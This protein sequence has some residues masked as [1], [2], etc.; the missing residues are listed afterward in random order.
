MTNITS[1]I[2]DPAPGTT[3]DGSIIRTDQYNKILDL[4]NGISAE[5][6]NLVQNIVTKTT[7]YSMVITDFH[8]LAN[9]VSAG[10]T[11]TLPDAT[12]AGIKNK[13]LTIKKIDSTANVI[14]VQGL[15]AQTIDGAN[16]HNLTQQN[17]TVF[18]QSDGTNWRIIAKFL[19]IRAIQLPLAPVLATALLI[20]L[21]SAP[22]GS[23]SA[24]IG[25]RDVSASTIGFITTAQSGEYVTDRIGIATLTNPSS[26]TITNATTLKI[27]GAPVASTNVTITNAYSLW[28]AGG[29]SK[30]DG[31]VALG[32]NTVTG[33][34][35][36]SGVP[37]VSNSASQAF[38]V[39]SSA[40]GGGIIVGG[41]AF[42]SVVLNSTQTGTTQNSGIDS[43]FVDST[44]TSVRLTSF[45]TFVETT[46]HGAHEGYVSIYTTHAGSLTEYFRVSGKNQNVQILNGNLSLSSNS[47]TTTLYSILDTFPTDVAEAIVFTPTS[48]NN[49][50]VIAVAPHGSNVAS[51]LVSYQ[52]GYGASNTQFALFGT[53]AFAQPE[54]TIASLTFGTASAHPINIYMQSANAGTTTKV[55]AFEADKSVSLYNIMTVRTANYIQWNDSGNANAFSIIHSPSLTWAFQFNGSTILSF[56]NTGITTMVNTLKPI[57]SSGT[58][59][60]SLDS[61]GG[62][63][64]VLTSGSTSTPFSNADNFAGAFIIYNTTSGTL[65]IVKVSASAVTMFTG[66]DSEF[67]NT[68]SPSSSQTG[69]YQSS[70][71]VTIKN[72]FAT[73]KTYVIMSFRM[74]TGI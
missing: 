46:T 27:M 61:S 50:G 26:G 8:V 55:W 1:L 10:F 47:I 48:G 16:I 51:Y 15:S 2:Y 40:S 43:Y 3:T 36:M 60:W 62:T 69:I 57:T 35:T 24:F 70:G 9:G 44:S 59:K 22:V 64:I 28:V 67:V 54:V 6:Y 23:S 29:V 65:A 39:N 31:N 17:E 49:N 37:T 52:T 30:F 12:V 53:G 7:S 71:V 5:N 13:I 68:S 19:G 41:N 73:S 74:W 56:D 42:P 38:I 18:I 33:S 63:T 72:G 58:A 20:T 66:S 14:A 11:V 34:F 45:A 4:I 32:S 25:A 21:P